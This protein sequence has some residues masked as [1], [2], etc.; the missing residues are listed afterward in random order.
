M[1]MKNTEF[2]QKDLAKKLG[3]NHIYLNAVI[4]GRVTPSIDLALR[5]EEE[6]SGK[7]KAVDLR[8]DIQALLKKFASQG[9]AGIGRAHQE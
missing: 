6:T 4:K 1:L 3:V 9:L 5:I 8:P 2:R 7:Y